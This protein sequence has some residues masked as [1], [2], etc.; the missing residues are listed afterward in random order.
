MFEQ[1]KKQSLSNAVFE[2]L[3]DR[4][5]RGEMEVGDPCPLNVFWP[6]SWGSTEARYVKV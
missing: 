1:V 3:K 6:K 5:V 4:I 2:Q